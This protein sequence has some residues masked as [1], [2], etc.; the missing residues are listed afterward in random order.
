IAAP[1]LAQFNVYGASLND[2]SAERRLGQDNTGALALARRAIELDAGRAPYWNTY[3]RALEATGDAAG[4]RD[5]YTEATRRA[6]TV[7]NYWINLGRIDALLAQKNVS[8]AKD[9]AYAA[10]RQA[11]QVDPNHPT[12]HDLLARLYF[13]FGDYKAALETER[14]AIALYPLVDS[15]YALAAECARRIDGDE[16]AFTI[17]RD[18]IARTESKDLRLTLARGLVAR[19]QFAEARAV[20]AAVLSAYPNDAQ[21]LDLLRQ[22]GDR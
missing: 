19:A 13:Q 7:A 20:L 1:L 18:G 2:R 14:Q 16:A 22:I 12:T 15:Y 8:G 11:I 3:G 5:A 6:P 21:A 4:A 17:L 10:A 9:A